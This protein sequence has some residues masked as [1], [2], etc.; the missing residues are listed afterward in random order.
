MNGYKLLPARV[1]SNP[2]EAAAFESWLNDSLTK[3]GELVC[4]S[5]T[6]SANMMIAVFRVGASVTLGNHG[7]W[8]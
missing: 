7:E 4:F 2:A 6:M 1:P 8:Q 5:P 3:G